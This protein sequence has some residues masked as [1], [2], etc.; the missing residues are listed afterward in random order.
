[1]QAMKWIA[2]IVL[3]I[4]L[5]GCGKIEKEEEETA[6]GSPGKEVDKTNRDE[7][8]LGEPA[9]SSIFQTP[10]KVVRLSAKN[11]FIQEVLHFE[12]TA[13]SKSVTCT[14]GASTVTSNA[15]ANATV[16]DRAR[17]FLITSNDH[18]EKVLQANG[19]TYT[20]VADLQATAEAVSFGFQ[21]ACLKLGGGAQDGTIYVPGP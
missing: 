2:L 12:T 16:N 14:Y 5:I 10:W 13:I 7:C 19:S 18:Q 15:R 20:C 3:S 9:N 11:V 4:S 1:M 21:S 8:L 17:Q 6:K